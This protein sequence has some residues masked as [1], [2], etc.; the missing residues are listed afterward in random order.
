[1]TDFF[2]IGARVTVHTSR[3]GPQ[4]VL[5]V[6][7]FSHEG[8]C[9]VLSDGSQWRADGRRQWGYRGSHYTG[10]VVE[11]ASD[12]DA[13]HVAKR[14]A[15]GA[16]RKWANDLDMDTPL[17]AESLQ[18]VLDIIAAETAAETAAEEAGRGDG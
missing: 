17:P 7:R 10:P 15:I 8:R 13:G 6:A 12:T 5:Q 18:R 1:M 14:R 16:L 11:T 4:S 9:M 3:G 2:K